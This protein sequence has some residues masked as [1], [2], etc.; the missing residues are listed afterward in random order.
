VVY[1]HAHA[2]G[3][4]KRRAQNAGL[5]LGLLLERSSVV[6]PTASQIITAVRTYACIDQY[7]KWAAPRRRM[8]VTHVDANGKEI[9]PDKVDPNW[10]LARTPRRSLETIE[11]F[12]AE[13]AAAKEAVATEKEK[14]RPRG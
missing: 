5:A 9:P 14:R 1:R 10:R 2:L 7:G 11:R 13:E 12:A 8:I 4:F 3:L 6:K